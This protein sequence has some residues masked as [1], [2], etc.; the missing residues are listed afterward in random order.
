MNHLI[1]A[2]TIVLLQSIQIASFTSHHHVVLSQSSTH[3]QNKKS[4][5]T[6]FP[7]IRKKSDEVVGYVPSG[8]TPEQYA[9][10]KKEELEQKKKMNFGA[11][12]PRFARSAR[13]DGDWMVVPSLWTGGFDSNTQY[14]N[15]STS[16]SNANNKNVVFVVNL[17]NAMKKV[18]P[19]YMVLLFVVEMITSSVYKSSLVT[20]MLSQVIQK[21]FK[22]AFVSIIGAMTLKCTLAKMLVATL[23]VKPYSLLIERC[24]RRLLWSPRRTMTI[25]SITSST[26]LIISILLRRFL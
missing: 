6:T 12:G 3:Q 5:F 7:M 8:L 24:N 22:N 19:I 26:V 25:S 11:W 16:I 9:K 15:R 10:I 23:L 14:S 2:L 21:D 13:P 20:T 4:T 17:M 18:L 1:K